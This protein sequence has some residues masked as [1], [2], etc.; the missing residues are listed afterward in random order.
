MKKIVII[1]IGASMFFLGR[2][3]VCAQK[4]KALQARPDA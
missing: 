3:V 1:G 4:Y 2:C